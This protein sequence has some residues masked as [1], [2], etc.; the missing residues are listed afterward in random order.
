MN[1]WMKQTK[2]K[3]LL[4]KNSTLWE[5]NSTVQR[6]FNFHWWHLKPFIK[7]YLQSECIEK[8]QFELCSKYDREYRFDAILGKDVLCRKL[9]LICCKHSNN[10]ARKVETLSKRTIYVVRQIY[11]VARHN[12][13]VASVVTLY[14]DCKTSK[15]CNRCI[16]SLTTCELLRHVASCFIRPVH[17]KT[18]NPWK[19][20]SYY[21]LNIKNHVTIIIKLHRAT[22]LR[23]YAEVWQWLWRN[24]YV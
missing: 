10:V 8:Y 6:K 2:R 22:R 4:T 24:F 21:I 1:I 5:H 16:F 14:H 9:R 11:L 12:F 23:L 20:M 19:P 13:Y 15:C 18:L 3:T 7:I 17:Y